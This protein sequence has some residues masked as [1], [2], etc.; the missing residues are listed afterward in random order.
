MCFVSFHSFI[1]ESN[2][3][4]IEFKKIDSKLDWS[5]KPKHCC[6][7]DA[8]TAVWAAVD[9]VLQRPIYSAGSAATEFTRR[10]CVDE[11]E[12]NENGY[13]PKNVTQVCTNFVRWFKEQTKVKLFMDNTVR[14][15]TVIT[16]LLH[17]Y[18]VQ[19]HFTW[20]K[21]APITL[22]RLTKNLLKRL[23]DEIERLEKIHD[24]KNAYIYI[25]IWTKK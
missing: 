2:N 18:I 23:Y 1:C 6:Q 4:L 9:T 19:V 14:Y 11:I 7:V 8:S 16:T 15:N 25:N 13:Y 10:F 12:G 24:L 3:W 20:Y 22:K 5:I 17:M 21:T